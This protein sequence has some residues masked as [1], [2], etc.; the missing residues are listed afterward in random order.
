MEI[1]KVGNKFLVAKFYFLFN[2]GYGLTSVSSVTPQD[3]VYSEILPPTT[4]SLDV[5][6]TAEV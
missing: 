5:I 6:G 1:Y 2:L 3:P 4:S